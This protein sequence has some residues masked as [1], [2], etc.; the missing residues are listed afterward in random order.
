[1]TVLAEEFLA[2]VIRRGRIEPLVSQKPPGPWTLRIRTGHEEVTVSRSHHTLVCSLAA[3]A[4]LPLLAGLAAEGEP[5][6]ESRKASES[7]PARTDRYGD[8]LPPGVLARLGTPRLCQPGTYWMAFSPDGNMLASMDHYQLTVRIWDVKTGEQIGQFETVR[9]RVRGGAWGP[10]PSFLAFS[11]GGELLATASVMDAS[12]RLWDVRAR[13]L[14]H[15]VQATTTQRF[16]TLAFSPDGR[17]LAAGGYG[18]TIHI[19]DPVKGEVVARWG[20]LQS[21]AR[22]AFTPDGKTLLSGNFSPRA[23]RKYNITF[24]Q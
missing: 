13:R 19:I 8:R 20:N 18:G 16:D 15:T 17:R 23:D 9:S 22:L 4:A 11:P 2:A 21:V 14:L 5:V 1:M 24:C 12:V 6:S 10:G 3:W 7:K